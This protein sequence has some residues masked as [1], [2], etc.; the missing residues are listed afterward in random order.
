MMTAVLL[1]LFAAPFL[2]RVL[3]PAHTQLV[4]LEPAAPRQIRASVLASGTLMYQ[5]QVQ[6]SSEVIGRVT[7]ILVQE[8]ERVTAGQALLRI[9]DAQSRAEV[10]QQQSVVRQQQINIDNQRL[11]LHNQESQFQRKQTLYSHQMIASSALEDAQYALDQ[12]RI[13]LRNSAEALQQTQA[14]LKQ[15]VD[16]AAKTVVTAP[17]NGTVTAIDIKTGETAVP[18][19]VGYRGSSLLTIANTRTLMAEI[20][21]DEADIARIRAGQ[22]VAIFTAAHPDRVLHGAVQSIALSP[23]R[24]DGA[25]GN[26]ALARSYL[27]KLSLTDAAGVLLHAGMSCRAE[28]YTAS[29]G[30]ALSAPLQAILSPAGDKSDSAEAALGERR[31][32]ASR[33]RE[34]G[35]GQYVLVARDGVVTRKPVKLGIAD[36]ERQEIISGLQ[37]G[38]AIITGPYKVLRQLK[39]GDRVAPSMEAS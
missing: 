32:V 18:N 1:A 33:Q 14:V 2:T 30:A 10:A 23:Q 26:G 7:A 39:S 24:N 6:L 38:D 35:S 21:V 22:Q 16:R 15:A 28:I 36:D 31:T 9:D 19:Q 13:Q 8:G 34:A 17:L 5:Q 12:A 11:A 37:L 20:S 25:A 27:I 3:R 29:A 4:T